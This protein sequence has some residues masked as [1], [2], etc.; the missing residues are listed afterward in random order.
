MLKQY[1]ITCKFKNAANVKKWEWGIDH[2]DELDNTSLGKFIDYKTGKI[3][4][5]ELLMKYLLGWRSCVF[6]GYDNHDVNP[7]EF[8]SV[9]SL[10]AKGIKCEFKRN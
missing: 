1:G 5:E 4:D 9:R 8:F 6:T 7:E 10:K 3:L 2:C